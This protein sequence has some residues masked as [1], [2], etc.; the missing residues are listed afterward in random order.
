[1]VNTPLETARARMTRRSFASLLLVALCLCAL[2]PSLAQSGRRKTDP[3]RQSPVPTPTPAAE[4]QGESESQPARAAKNAS[5]VATFVVYEDDSLE[6]NFSVA[7]SQRDIVSRTFFER[8]RQSSAVEVTAG[9]RGTRG[10]ARERAKKESTAYAVHLQLEEDMISARDRQQRDTSGRNEP[11]MY[12]LRVSVYAPSTGDLKYS[13]IIHQ[14]PYRPTARVGGI[15]VPVPVGRER[16]P[17]EYQLAQV[18]RDAADRLLSRFDIA[19]PP[20][21]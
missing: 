1:M 10:T 7:G 12:A 4:P 19:R 3:S 16:I 13:D 5:I 11:G 14:R 8:L 2:V 20:E 9:G 17:G 18:A 15:P 6:L 21:N